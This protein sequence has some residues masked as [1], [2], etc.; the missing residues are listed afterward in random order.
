MTKKQLK[1]VLWI[2]FT[3]LFFGIFFGVSYLLSH[4]INW[5]E[6]ILFFTIFGLLDKKGIG[7]IVDY[8]TSKFNKASKDSLE[9]KDNEPQ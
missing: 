4:S 7:Y 9:L 8:Y 2:A 1:V 6:A 3:A 5:I